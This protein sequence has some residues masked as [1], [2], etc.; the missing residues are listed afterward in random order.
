MMFDVDGL[1]SLEGT[2]N[3]TVFSIFF[4]SVTKMIMMPTKNEHHTKIRR[5]R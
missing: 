4:L 3:G 5:G 2:K 1:L